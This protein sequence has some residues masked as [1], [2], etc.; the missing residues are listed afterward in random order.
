[1]TKS[2]LAILFFS[3]L[4]DASMGQ[5]DSKDEFGLRILRQ[6]EQ[7]FCQGDTSQTV[8]I[9]E[10]YSR[11]YPALGIT[12]LVN[13]R[14]AEFYAL[15][16][17]TEGAMTLLTQSLEARPREGYL[18]YKDSCGL[19]TKLDPAS[20]KADICVAISKIYDSLGDSQAALN[21]LDLA[22]N[23]YLPDYGGCANGM[24]MYKTNLSLD[25]ADH[26]MQAGNPDKALDRLF[27]YFL[28]NEGYDYK[29]TAKLKSILLLTYTQKQITKEINRGLKKMSIVKNPE[30]KTDNILLMTFFGR[31]I[32]K[33]A[34]QDLKSSRDTY[35]KHRNI[36]AL[37]GG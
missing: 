23:K 19:F 7:S 1:M 14:L 24:I 26:Y 20:T 27:E 16:G 17:N 35:R 34:Y 2:I 10:N 29:V 31:T 3:I 15:D 18:R 33:S 9:L 37:M 22:D 30:S 36:V 28:S 5:Q 11:D 12:L 4:A 13:K 21:F 25:F 6:A 32:K 8:N